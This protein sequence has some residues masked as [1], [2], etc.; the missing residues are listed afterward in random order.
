MAYAPD[1]LPDRESTLAPRAQAYTLR[2]RHV[3]DVACA[4]Y[5][6]T[7][8]GDVWD[9]VSDAMARLLYAVSH[10]PPGSVSLALSFCYRPLGQ[11]PS[12]QDR[13]QIFF[14]VKARTRQLA[15]QFG[16]LAER[17]LLGNFYGLEPCAAPPTHPDALEGMAYVC[18]REEVYEPLHDTAYNPRSI[19]L[20]AVQGFAGKKPN[21][22]LGLDRMLDTLQE[23]AR[24]DI[25]L[26]PADLGP[27]MR[28]F[29]RY[30]E[31][32][33]DINH[34]PDRYGQDDGP[35]L[36]PVDNTA[37][38]Y[39]P[40]STGSVPHKREP[41]ADSILHLNRRTIESLC[42]PHL[43][44][45]VRICAEA[46]DT[47]RLL[48]AVVASEA[49]EDA[50]WRLHEID[51]NHPSFSR[52][53]E[54]A[55]RLELTELDTHAEL[56][57]E[58]RPRIYEGLS[59]MCCLAPAT[60]LLSLVTLPTAAS[61]PL[62]CMRRNTDPPHVPR[63]GALVIGRDRECVYTGENG[64]LLGR[65][66]LLACALLRKSIGVFGLPGAGKSLF[67][68]NLALALRAHDV[69]FLIFAPI[70]KDFRV[71]KRPEVQTLGDGTAL[72]YFT[73]ADDT[74]SPFRLNPFAWSEHP[75][76]EAHKAMLLESLD[77]AFGIPE[78][79]KHVLARALDKVYILYPT[80]DHPPTMREFV[81][82]ALEVLDAVGY[83]GDV[84]ENLSAALKN[85]LESL[86]S[87]P[88]GRVFACRHGNVT[89]DQLLSGQN[90]FEFE[91]LPLRDAAL[92]QHLILGI[93][94]EG[95]SARAEYALQ[96]NTTNLCIM[97][98]ESHVIIGGGV[99]SSDPDLP[100]P[101][102]H[103][104]EQFCRGICEL[105]GYGIGFVIADQLA[106]K[107]PIDVLKLVQTKLL[108]KQASPDEAM[109]IGITMGFTEYEVDAAI[110]LGPGEGFWFSDGYYRPSPIKTLPPHVVPFEDDPISG[111]DL[112]A[113]LEGEAWFV[114]AATAAVREAA[115]RLEG[116]LAEWER[117]EG[118]LREKTHSLY[119]RLQ[120]LH[121]AGETK[122]VLPAR[123]KIHSHAVSLLKE[124]N[125]IRV[126][127]FMDQGGAWLDL[128][129]PDATEP[130][131]K[132]HMT[133]LRERYHNDLKPRH[134]ACCRMLQT[135]IDATKGSRHE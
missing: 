70:K 35:V 13:L 106:T 16:H 105:R 21:R 28:S 19:P 83:A 48:G 104:T 87:G 26:E 115:E 22:W 1:R 45:N 111:E 6:R 9:A 125:G 37:P 8:A 122:D 14:T 80:P 64:E 62:R 85:R 69:P 91:G 124:L 89:R 116:L 15:R 114:E 73:P 54:A 17:D 128:P 127:F 33:N 31:H 67:L 63:E 95:A 102:E 112:R 109:H 100:D 68:V 30:V 86:T 29:T 27:V 34:P 76:R 7:A 92:L 84:S 38:R 110:R 131:V 44:F 75:G 135:V 40:R 132:Q 82:V 58:K 88:I 18:R 93:V 10:A 99:K 11:V 47:A 98:D 25:V 41:L 94:R 55:L 20:Y 59:Q 119:K 118:P 61:S 101:R 66:I 32:L 24:V 56:F 49:F 50:Q 46:P 60:Q 4:E 96:D 5:R 2:A 108:Q 107:I 23:A 78:P 79:L 123:D 36:E 113:I 90:V 77:A 97:I 126:G 120:S 12:S 71:L 72:C 42:E 117:D 39:T 52:H 3:P 81:A 130:S 65:E 129:V 51:G 103:V 133:S 57:R 43:R 121:N 74:V 134:E 53:A